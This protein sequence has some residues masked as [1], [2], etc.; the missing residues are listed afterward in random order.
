[1]GMKINAHLP[2]PADFPQI[3]LR[4]PH[5]TKYRQDNFYFRDRASHLPR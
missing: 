3:L 5:K 2:I 4:L 1:M